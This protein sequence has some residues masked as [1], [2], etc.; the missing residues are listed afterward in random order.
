MPRVTTFKIPLTLW[1]LAWAAKIGLSILVS[2]AL[3]TWVGG[4][5]GFLAFVTLTMWALQRDTRPNR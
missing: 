3:G 5:L 1:L 2:D 4:A